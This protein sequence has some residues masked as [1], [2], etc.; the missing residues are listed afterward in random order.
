LL[1]GAIFDLGETL[2]HLTVSW[3]EVRDWRVETIHRA[4][5]D[6]GVTLD[7]NDVKQQYMR[8]HEE[9]SDYAA[10]TLVEIE[11]EGTFARLLDRLSVG[12]AQ[13]P[14]M[15]DLVKKS[16][17]LEVNSWIT[18]PG[19]QA[20]LRKVR[21]L[22][23]KVGLLSNARSDWAVREIV[24]QRGLTEYFDSILTS[25]A[26]GIRKPRPEPFLQM[27]KQL[28]LEANEAVMVGNSIEADIAGAKP[29]GIKTIHVTFGANQNEDGPDPDVTVSAVSEIIPAIRRIATSC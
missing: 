18:F 25:A 8:L 11:I 15:I 16:F 7:L 10:R 13:R 26:I 3:E 2:I 29:L 23:L 17:E 5:R 6:R 9:E 4:L 12:K 19:T 21:Q 1:K 14:A 27:L 24:E 20:M 22:G 28:D